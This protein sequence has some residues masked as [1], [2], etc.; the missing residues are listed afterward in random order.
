MRTASRQPRLRQG[1]GLARADLFARA[2]KRLRITIQSTATSE[3]A[4]TTWRPNQPRPVA[5][6][7]CGGCEVLTDARLSD[8]IE[9]KRAAAYTTDDPQCHHEH[10][11]DVRHRLAGPDRA[12]VLRGD[13]R[14]QSS[15]FE[16]FR[17][18][19]QRLR[20]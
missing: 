14:L 19:S 13:H 17:E 2:Q 11:S 16:L 18:Q 12:L 6:Q 8:A 4:F 5:Q 10:A 1:A 9:Q 7:S 3:R 20:A 15:Q